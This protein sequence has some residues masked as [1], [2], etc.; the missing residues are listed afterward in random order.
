VST[1]DC[2]ASLDPEER[3]KVWERL[4]QVAIE[5]EA[6]LVS[7]SQAA[8]LFRRATLSR[9]YDE[10]ARTW[11]R[12]NDTL[13][14]TRRFREIIRAEAMQLG[15]PVIA[16]L[17]SA[18]GLLS[19]PLQDIA[20]RIYC[21]DNAPGMVDEVES[22]EIVQR[23]QGD[24]TNSGL[25]DDSIDL[26]ICARVVEYLFDPDCL[27]DEIKRIGRIGAKYVVTFPA[28]RDGLSMHEGSRTY[29]PPDQRIRRYF[30]EDDLKDWQAKLVRVTS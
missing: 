5:K 17:G 7:F 19:L 4:V 23:C 2:L 3:L 16:D 1:H 30:S 11:N 6:I 9:F 20:S 15:R 25:P 8:E 27:V 29:L 24:V 28:F 18:G 12:D 10:N 26:V 22:T 21:V 13:Y 14:R